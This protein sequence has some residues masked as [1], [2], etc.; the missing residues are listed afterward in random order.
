MLITNDQVD[1]LLTKL[2]DLSGLDPKLTE[3]CG[4]LI[5]SQQY[6]EAVSRAFVVLEERLRELLG[7]RGGAGVNLS[8]KA[9]APKSGQLVD[10]LLLPAAEVE[11][12]RDLFV[13]AFKA[14]RNRAAHTM[15][16]Y[17]LDEARAVIH[18]VNLLLLMLEKARHVPMRVP[19]HIA[20]LLNP[21]AVERLRVFLERLEDIGISAAEGKEWIPYKALVKYQHPTWD[22]PRTHQA[23]LFYLMVRANKPMISFSTYTLARVVGLDMKQLETD[24]M[25]AGC[26]RDPAKATSIRLLLDQHNDQGTFDRLSRILQE[27]MDKHRVT[28]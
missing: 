18:L 12:M 7:V 10:R 20:Q 11:G 8:E 17:D 3:V 4:P 14:F 15:A 19:E 6:D 23:T 9:F 22:K 13:G 28:G 27:L 2:S 24:L 21:T 1:D 5:R 16:G 25:Q 26:L